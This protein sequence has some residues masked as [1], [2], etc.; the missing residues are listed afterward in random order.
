MVAEPLSINVA[1]LTCTDYTPLGNQAREEG[2]SEIAHHIWE[3]DRRFAGRWDLE[4]VFFTENSGRYPA[5]AKQGE[6]LGE[7]FE[8]IV[9]H[10]SPE[11]MGF[12][13]RRSRTFSAG[14][15]RRTVRWLGPT[16]PE[17]V[18]KLFA[19][20]FHVHLQLG[21]EE[22]FVAEKVEITEWLSK[23]ASQ[24]HVQLPDGWQ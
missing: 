16:C 17:D 5:L 22:Y 7:D 14:L 21:G 13:V 20:M 8:L 18:E 15:N 3:T 11:H 1:G 2:A 6:G 9:V 23:V 19:T 24:R 4:D 10:A 12:P